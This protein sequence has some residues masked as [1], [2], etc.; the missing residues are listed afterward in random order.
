MYVDWLSQQE[1]ML[2]NLGGCNTSA[3]VALELAQAR[4]A[5]GKL[6]LASSSNEAIIRE[7]EFEMLQERMR[8]L[9][10]AE[11]T[12]C[13]QDDI[14]ASA[15]EAAKREL[16][17]VH[18][19]DVLMAAK[20]AAI[21]AETACAAKLNEQQQM[22]LAE[23]ARCTTAMADAVETTT[24]VVEERCAR[25]QRACWQNSM[26]SHQE[27]LT[28]SRRETALA[29]A[30]LKTLSL[31][32]NEDTQHRTAEV[33]EL[34]KVEQIQ[35]AKLEQQAR[36]LE[37]L[38]KAKVCS[39]FRGRLGEMEIFE[40]LREVS[41]G[42]VKDVHRDGHKADFLVTFPNNLA[43]KVESKKCKSYRHIF[44]D[45]VFAQLR[46]LGDS[47]DVKIKAVVVVNSNPDAVPHFTGGKD[48]GGDNHAYVARNG[49][50]GQ[51]LSGSSES[52]QASLRTILQLVNKM[53]AP[54]DD[55]EDD[56][57][58]YQQFLKQ[59]QEVS[60]TLHDFRKFLE[61]EKAR[62]CTDKNQTQKQLSLVEDK[63]VKVNSKIAEFHM[64]ELEPQKVLEEAALMVQS[65]GGMSRF[66]RLKDFDINGQ[67]HLH[68]QIKRFW[69][70]SFP[71]F[72][73]DLSKTLEQLAKR[74]RLF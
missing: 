46:Q 40:F 21:E 20:E 37:E 34:R 28:A 67:K 9:E 55:I 62:L 68:A 51:Y 23:R 14:I 13:K 47:N 39:N 56:D 59:K 16:Q 24:R 36:E 45:D 26:M 27:L 33:V 5:L 70:K 48:L 63:L 11:A 66:Q 72:S 53:P 50:F 60:T 7:L 58:D 22:T 25:E 52:W 30:E 1:T 44:E 74:A 71:K 35:C 17:R 12:R 42:N 8:A 31:K 10:K 41:E 6:E 54:A 64:E 49:V 2:R 18:A 57:L 38:H 32:C 3:E 4:E 73:D 19:R 61:G 29:L 65:N 43:V 15:V 69:P